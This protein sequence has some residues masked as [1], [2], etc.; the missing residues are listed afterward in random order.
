MDNFT[1]YLQNQD[2]S[3]KAGIDNFTAKVLIPF[4]SILIGVIGLLASTNKLPVWAS[5]AM[6]IYLVII[7]GKIFARPTKKFIL[8]TVSQYNQMRFA[9]RMRPNLLKL[10]HELNEL[11]D[12]ERTNT[13][14]YFTSQIF[15]RLSQ[16]V[17]VLSCLG[18][19]RQQ[20][21]ILQSWAFSLKCNFRRDNKAEFIHNAAQLSDVVT[22][23]IWACVWLRQAVDN[24]GVDGLRT[25]ILYLTGMRLHV[26]FRI[27]LLELNA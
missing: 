27:L 3:S 16:E 12:F 7:I 13:I 22:W 26:G 10:S 1:N 11:L 4:G 18:M 8:K 15:S 17:N 25:K 14:P 19:S 9:K 2:S 5:W 20:F 6:A 23:F 24:L 21:T